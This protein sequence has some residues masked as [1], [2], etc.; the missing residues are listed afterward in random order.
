MRIRGNP[1]LPAVHH[2]DEHFNGEGTEFTG[3]AENSGRPQFGMVI[4]HRSKADVI[5]NA[6]PNGF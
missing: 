1:G 2:S 4:C 3:I 6:S 5:G